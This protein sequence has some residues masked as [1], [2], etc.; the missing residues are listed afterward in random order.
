MT[1]PEDNLGGLSAGIALEPN[2]GAFTGDW[3]EYV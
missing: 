2:N 1:L 3:R